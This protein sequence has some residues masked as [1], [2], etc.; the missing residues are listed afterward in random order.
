MPRMESIS[1]FGTSVIVH[2][3][4]LTALAMIQQNL[5][6][7]QP[8]VVLET[9]FEEERV[10]EEFSQKLEDSPEVSETQSLFA[11]GVVS[12]T[13]GGMS[14][15]A[16][17]E[18][19]IETSESL[20]EP[21]IRV[22]LRE[23]ALPGDNML[24][25]D[26]GSEEVSGETGAVVEGYGAALQRLTQELLRLMR[27]QKVFVVWL[28]DESES[29]K[30]DQRQIAKQ[31]HT[32]YEELGIQQQKDKK[33][34]IQDQV[35]LT[36]VLG[37]GEKIHEITKDPTTDVKE[38]QAAIG[39][40]AIDKTGQENMCQS[41]VAVL[42]KY[43]VMAARQKRT[44]VVVVVSDESPTDHEK[45]EDA[46]SRAKR[47]KSPVYIMGREAV[48][49][50]PFA[51][52]HWLDPEFGMPHRV[53]IDRGPETAFVECLQYDGFHERLES[54]PSGFGPYSMVRIS[55]ESGGIY[56]M[57]PGVDEKM[58]EHGWTKGGGPTFDPLSMKE[59][60]PL[61]LPRREY[62]EERQRSKFRSKIW[63]VIT[64]LNPYQD[65]QLK[66]QTWHLPM[67]PKKF[68]ENAKQQFAKA[69][70]AIGILSQATE[71][72]TDIK[73]LRATEA[74]PRWRAAYDLMLA[75]CTAYRVRLFQYMLALDK[76][77]SENTKPKDKKSNRWDVHSTRERIN[78][79]DAQ[80]DRLRR[81]YNIKETRE[82]YL[83]RLDVARQRADE[84]Y[85][86][87]ETEHPG[88]P[89]AVRARHER[90]RGYGVRLHDIFWDEAKYK[91]YQGKV[92]NF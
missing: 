7:E 40:I 22:N 47:T 87:V 5:M 49:G 8:K 42:E 41:L 33:L 32:V 35:L 14:A 25:E 30:S 9:F 52:F 18:E 63:D 46:I 21:D 75:Q 19:K 51:Y 50:Y 77:V 76:Q 24:S 31:F 85:R 36:V 68:A 61:L 72:L 10:Q 84:A 48:F 73:P 86:F 82:E 81:A 64:T 37:F 69:M 54:F 4:A 55:K 26:L 20:A 79:E 83:Q 17:V 28:F 43:G 70:R 12:T 27:E 29:M 2:A 78:P 1:G 60:R 92:P 38:I 45:V 44:L 11:G 57:L 39:K 34:R 74:S 58:S 91:K 65:E 16:V 90:E 59:Y 88:T 67:E 71:I 62:A 23:V 66:V 80:F 13:V 53:R 89:W 6:S 56:F 3:V 15:P